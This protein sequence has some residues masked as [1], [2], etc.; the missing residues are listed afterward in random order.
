MA[1]TFNAMA[2][3]LNTIMAEKDGLLETLKEGST[4]AGK[5]EG[6]NG[7]VEACAGKMVRTETLAAVQHLAAGIAHEIN[8]PLT[9]AS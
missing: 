9:N 7:G 2:E 3:K 8:N 1:E 5:K 4:R 6:G